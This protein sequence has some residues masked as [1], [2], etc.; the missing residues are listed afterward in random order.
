MKALPKGRGNEIN[1]MPLGNK[2][3]EKKRE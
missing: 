3:K 2:E 1:K